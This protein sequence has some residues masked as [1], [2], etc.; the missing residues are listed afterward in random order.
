M[1]EDFNGQSRHVVDATVRFRGVAFMIATAGSF[2]RSRDTV[3]FSNLGYILAREASGRLS[4]PQRYTWKC[5]D[6]V[7][8][9]INFIRLNF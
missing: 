8:F 7:D 4:W 6:T 2:L 1:W 5:G 9:I 3:D